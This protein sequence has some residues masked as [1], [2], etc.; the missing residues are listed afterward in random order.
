MTHCPNCWYPVQ[1]SDAQFCPTCGVNLHQWSQVAVS[2]SPTVNVIVLNKTPI[3]IGRGESND[4]R[5]DH[6]AVSEHHAW[7][8]W[9]SEANAWYVADE[10]SAKGTFV[11]YQRV[12]HGPEGWPV[13]PATDTVWIAP[14]SFR[15][16]G[17]DHQQPRF[18]PARMRLDARDLVRTV[19]H[20]KTRQSV[21]ILN[22]EPTPLS[23]RPGEFIALVGG[24]GAGKTTL[25][26]ALLG[27]SPA[28]EGIVYVSGRPFIEAGRT[29]RFEAMHTVVGYVPQDD[30]VHY[31]LTPL[32]AMDYIARFRLS[33]DLSKSERMGYIQKTLETVELWPHRN[34][35]IRKLSG[36]QR[37]R[38]NIAL[39]LLAEPRL[40]FLDEPTSGLD[41]GLDLSV[42]ELL[43]NWATDPA[44]PRTI[45]L[46]T[47]ATEN[48]TSCKYVAFMATGG[49]VVYFGP[50]AQALSYFGVERFAEIYRTI[51]TYQP[52][53]LV[54]SPEKGADEHTPS[55]PDVRELVSSFQN[56]SDFFKYIQARQLSEQ[57]AVSPP[58]EVPRPI[59]RRSILPTPAESDRFW[60]Q[61]KILAV[62]YWK[63]I[64]RDRMNF[65]TLLLQGLLVAGLLWAVSRPDTF[66]PKGAEDAQTVLF[67]MA[68]AAVWLGIL[69]GTKEIVKEQDIYLR[70]RRYGLGAVPYVLSKVAILALIG[71]IQIGTLLA[72]ISYHLVLPERGAL[73][74]WS[75][76]WL[77]WFVTLELTLVA[78]LSLGLFLSASTTTI[79]AATAVMFVLLVIQVMFA[80][81]FF[82]D[83]E[84]ADTLS[85]FT[86]SRWG[87][88]GVATTANLNGLLARAIG[89]A[90][91]PDEAYTFSALHLL[92]RWAILGGYAF[93]LVATASFRQ[94]RKR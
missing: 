39:E 8:E 48:V 11:N 12:P 70:E 68:C 72:I 94:A 65:I 32:E 25:M 62:R 17:G 36:G 75:P 43:R 64:R 35:L 53:E 71:A 33:S 76:A 18:E 19:K 86:F 55:A 10:N 87:L 20:E 28:Q 73:G 23:F 82:P 84:W 40:L 37:K 49:Y 52:H 77:E 22:L 30:V 21:A 47:H 41:P 78:G 4:I 85:I 3:A 80:G 2:P 57:E 58:T 51:G 90:Y 29:Q 66:Q 56:S 91:Q 69:N 5:L 83:A 59:G 27:L 88:E 60:R 74:S 46:V 6:P 92:V 63:L 38:V 81:L 67:I 42:M 45:I 50:P 13:N 44:D 14:Y 9:R 54:S 31:D 7:L 26:K 1:E 16:A 34:K 61:F 24:S 79:D 15:L 89:S 93:I